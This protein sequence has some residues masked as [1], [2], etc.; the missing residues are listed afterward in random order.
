MIIVEGPDGSGKS[1]LAEKL[2]VELKIPIAPKA[3]SGSMR[4]MTPL[5]KYIDDSLAGFRRI[6]Y[7]RHA[8][9]SGPIYTCA[10]RKKVQ[11]AFDDFGQMSSW[12]NRFRAIGPLTIICLP[13][14]D[15]VWKNC[16]RDEDNRR[17]FP[18]RER[19]EAVYYQYLT[20]AAKEPECLLY[21]YTQ[22]NDEQLVI[23][24]V[25]RTMERV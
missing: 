25:A 12:Y 1:S 9:I 14:V 20:Y 7:D 5:P 18:D 13:P 19:V 6:I 15:E 8:L 3:V 23:D 4:I 16:Q 22:P 2:C 10:M 24:F 21:D 17:L 11:E